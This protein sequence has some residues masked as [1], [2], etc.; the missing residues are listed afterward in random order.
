[1]ER[2]AGSGSRQNIGGSVRGGVGAAAAI[3]VMKEERE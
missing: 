2:A 3:I 1:M